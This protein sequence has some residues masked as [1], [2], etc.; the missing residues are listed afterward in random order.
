MRFTQCF[1]T[2]ALALAFSFV[3]G[4]AQAQNAF[5]YEHINY[6]GNYA[7]ASNSVWW[8]GE[9][10]NDEISSVYML[11]GVIVTLFEHSDF[12]GQS[13]QL[14][15]QAPD[16]R[17]FSGPGPDGTWNDATSSIVITIP[18][19]GGVT[20]TVLV[21]GSFNA[22]PEWMEA[23]SP[24]FMAV[25]STM[26]KAPYQHRWMQN[27]NVTIFSGYSGIYEGGVD[28]A[29]LLAILPAGDVNL[30]AHSHGGN[31]VMRATQLS[32]RPIR[33]LIN[34]GTPV[35]FDLNR[36]LGS[37]VY[38]SCLVSSTSDQTQFDG[39]SL[40]IQVIPRY[41]YYYA[42]IYYGNLAYQALQQGNYSGYDYYLSLSQFYFSV[43]DSLFWS[44]KIEVFGQTRI[45]IGLSHSDLHEP[46]A[47]SQIAPHCAT[48]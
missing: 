25:A 39:A 23:T 2:L 29:N 21:N 31:V 19:P 3:S 30:I 45:L 37:P 18:S 40:N 41:D 48:N 28:L 8:V 13:L 36:Y 14:T 33:H 24:M 12:A 1:L 47:W 42:G 15:S 46:Y 11:P 34:L 43:S 16:L 6:E 35:N 5:F 9:D 44:T 20:T 38:S 7:A 17:W 10:W 32:G 22:Y 27:G 26:G 4:L